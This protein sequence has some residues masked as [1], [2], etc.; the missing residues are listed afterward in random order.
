MKKF[1]FPLGIAALLIAVTAAFAF[2]APEHKTGKTVI[3]Y[4]YTSSSSLLAD[5]QNISNWVAEDPACGSSGTKPCAI[6]FDGTLSEFDT[7]LDTYT[8]ASQV[9]AAAIKKKN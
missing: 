5:M 3:R 2:N 4:H 7:Q 8:S 6:D 9:T 1:K